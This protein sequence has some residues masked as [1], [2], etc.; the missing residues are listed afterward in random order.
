MKIVHE[1]REKD[2]ID[3]DFK[4]V[5]E[6]W[7]VYDLEDGS[8]IRV[9]IVISNIARV[10]NEFDNEGNPVYVAKMSSVM[11]VS[12]PDHLRKGADKKPEAH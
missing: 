8:R 12:T 1:G 9:K 3:I 6:E 11:S 4:T 7:N 2:A 5:N 10:I